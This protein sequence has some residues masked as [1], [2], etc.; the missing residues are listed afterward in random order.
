MYLYVV[1][2]KS[3]IRKVG[4]EGNTKGFNCI[5]YIIFLYFLNSGWN[6]SW[7]QYSRDNFAS[8][9]RLAL[10]P[11]WKFRPPHSWLC[12]GRRSREWNNGRRDKGPIIRSEIVTHSLMSRPSVCTVSFKRHL[13]VLV[14]QSCLSLCNPM[15]CNPPGFS[16][17]SFFQARILE[18]VAMLSFRV[19]SPPRDQTPVLLHCSQILYHLSHQ[20]SPQVNF[21]LI[22]EK[23]CDWNKYSLKFGKKPSYFPRGSSFQVFPCCM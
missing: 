18:W 21:Y 19:S 17:L 2:I 12:W 15:N 9:L 14:A 10:N 3:K 4:Q 13:N 1:K 22:F 8:L 7:L 6:K 16:V 23:G 20:G 11:F 5:W